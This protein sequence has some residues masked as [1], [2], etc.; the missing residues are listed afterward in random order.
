MHVENNSVAL[1]QIETYYMMNYMILLHCLA[2]CYAKC[3]LTLRRVKVGSKIA[4]T[5]E[6][7]DSL[8]GDQRHILMPPSKR[9]IN[10]IISAMNVLLDYITSMDDKTMDCQFKWLCIRRPQMKASHIKI[11]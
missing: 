1:W 7:G 5:I 8:Y 9:D 4:V 2:L 6:H 11:V 10:R 3:A